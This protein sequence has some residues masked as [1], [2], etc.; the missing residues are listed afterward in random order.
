[1]T[2]FCCLQ[3]NSGESF[4]YGRNEIWR[5]KQCLPGKLI[6]FCLH[7]RSWKVLVPTLY[8]HFGNL[9]LNTS[10]ACSI[11]NP[12]PV[13]SDALAIPQQ[14]GDPRLLFF[15]TTL[16]AA[17]L[18][19]SSHVS[20]VVMSHILH[21]VETWNDINNFRVRNCTFGWILTAPL[22]KPTAWINI[23][24]NLSVNSRSGST[25]TST[26]HSFH[27]H[28]GCW[29]ITFVCKIACNFWFMCPSAGFQSITIVQL[30]QQWE[31]NR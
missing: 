13:P 4:L 29:N 18:H 20:R 9:I 16:V 7:L 27:L 23:S 24:W 14:E 25:P 2:S 5:A 8:G 26:P 21:S 28:L 19:F 11:T 6:S 1:M 22:P 31:G 3:C 10:F 12:T 17:F 15:S 30:H